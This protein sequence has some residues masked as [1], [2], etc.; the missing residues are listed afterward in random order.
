MMNHSK[1]E[2]T[3][4]DRRLLGNTLLKLALPR[5]LTRLAVVLV[6][7]LG[8][9]WL[10]T[11]VVNKG[12]TVRYDGLEAFGQQVVDFLTRINIYIWWGL[13]LIL[14]LIVIGALRSWLRRSLAR[15]R[16][17]LVPLVVI[18]NLAATLS[19]EALDVLRW[20]WQ[21]TE[22]PITVGNLQQTLRQL[23]SGRVRKLALARAQK[24]SLD[25]AGEI[26]LA[27]KTAPR[28]VPGHREPVW[29]P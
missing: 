29:R 18:N 28:D 24:A 10:S 9:L 1:N 25:H 5:L 8:W 7:A 4:Q 22:V 23:R 3:R 21:D 16:A 20:V 12:K 26:L 11:Y 2:N 14:T 27:E 13:V 17:S 6:V 19:T 15:G